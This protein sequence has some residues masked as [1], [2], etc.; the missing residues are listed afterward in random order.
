MLHED[1]FNEVVNKY[2]LF[3]PKETRLLLDIRDT[4]ACATCSANRYS[5]NE[6]NTPSLS[7]SDFITENCLANEDLP[8]FETDTATPKPTNPPISTAVTESPAAVSIPTSPP[9]NVVLPTPPP[10]TGVIPTSPPM[11]TLPPQTGSIPTNP[12]QSGSLPTLP[13][14]S[15]VLPTSPPQAGSIP[16]NPPQPGSLPTLPPQSGATFTP[17]PS[18]SSITTSPWDFESGVFPEIPW[19]TGGNGVWTIDTENVDEGMYS[20]KSPDLQST[21]TA[22]VS[23]ATLTLENNFEGGLVRA[24]VLASVAPPIDVFIIYVD[25]VSAAQVSTHIYSSLFHSN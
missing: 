17:A 14:Q 23:N 9:M 6:F 19:R 2:S 24:R 15:G 21:Q 7:C 1:D 20:I 8:T 18:T 25:G 12:P 10:Q 11:S 3:K 16:T 4:A 13:P 22:G 5:I